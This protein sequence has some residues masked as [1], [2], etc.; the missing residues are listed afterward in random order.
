MKGPFQRQDATDAERIARFP[1]RPARPG[2]E[3]KVAV[4]APVLMTIAFLLSACV[5]DARD[6]QVRMPV[7]VSGKVTGATGPIGNAIVQVQGTANRTASADDGSFKLHGEGLGGREA[8]TVTA[9]VDGHYIGA[10]RVEPATAEQPVTIA[11]Q[12]LFDRDNHEYTWFEFEGKTGAESCGVC[13]REFEE[14][15]ADAHSRTATNYRFLNLYRGT[16]IQNRKSQPTR[17]IAEGKALP[18]D[19]A[20]PDYG[21]GF[22]LDNGDRA[23]NCATCHTPMAAKIETTNGCAWSG[24]HSSTTAERAEAAKAVKYTI[25]GASPVGMAGVALEGVGCEFCHVVQNVRL[26]PSTRLPFGDAPGILS[27]ELRRP[28]EGH[29]AFFGTIVDANRV[30]V[31]YSPQMATSQFCAACHY[32]VMGGVVS[33]MKMT[34]GV[35]VYNSYGEWLD[36]PYSDPQTG[37]SCQDCHMP[38]TKAPSVKAEFGGVERPGYSYHDH[39]MLGA[40]SPTLM[41]NALDVTGSAA[42][43]GDA[44]RVD[45]AVTNNRT[46][47]AVPTDA[48]IRSVMLVVEAFDAGGKPLALRDGPALPEWTG[49]YAGR[50]GR[51]Y[52][53]ILKDLWTGETPTA[54]Y[55]RQVELVEDTRLFPSKTDASRYVFDAPADAAKVTVKLIYRPAFYKV[56]QQKGWPDEDFLMNELSIPVVN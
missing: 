12:P 27:L 40:D 1:W 38:A 30:E 26:D 16:D 47:H 18:P 5:L 15:K 24:C 48:P 3:I 35:T 50:A 21:P 49:N 56:A 46:G 44:L 11:L 9:W 34:G 29:K 41:W 32:G 25:Q 13:H 53:K 39:K 42:R 19:P 2:V 20:L 7:T 52:A 55:W 14:W 6:R 4:L 51:G 43:E 54:A 45:V 36:S 10:A 23:G 17:L 31:T 37:K 22:K 8:I 28:P 33:N